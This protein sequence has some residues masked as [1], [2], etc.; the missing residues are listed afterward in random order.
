MNTAVLEL[1]P[2]LAQEA[3]G[4]WA[5]FCKAAAAAGLRVPE[6]P[7]LAAELQR[8]FAFSDFVAHSVARDPG[9]VVDLLAH[10]DLEAAYAP[11]RYRGKLAEA[12][13]AVDAEAGLA[14][15]LRKLRRREM[16]RIAWRDLAGRAD[17]NVTM[18]ELSRL[19]DACLGQTLTRLYDWQCAECGTPSAAGAAPQPLVVIGMGK[20]GARELN[21]SSDIDLVFAFPSAGETRGGPEPMD[22]HAFFVRLARR[23]VGVIGQPSADGPMYRVDLRLRPFG[24]NGPLVMSFDGMEDYY[25]Q[26][27]RE[28][29][30]YAWIKARSVAGD[31]AAGAR[32]LAAL[33][34]FVFRRYLDYGTIESIREMKQQISLEV[35]RKGLRDNI[36][37]GPGGIRE[38]EFFG[39]VFQLIRGGVLPALQAGP[40]QQTLDTL[41][42]ENLV[43]A[44][45]CRELQAAYTFLRNTEHRLQMAADR[46]THQ[47]PQEE[48][49][50]RRLAVSMGFESWTAFYARL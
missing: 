29:E 34:P 8:V 15:A 14:T 21:F 40:I 24:E 33:K 42:A 27:G 10:G 2:V 16:V 20:L 28:W 45:V 47:L 44:G 46:Q 1:P 48:P 7:G 32:L 9:L 4:K 49:A 36:K 6:R 23:L 43:P 12:L 35:G 18:A 5:A 25:Q 3:A 30:R 26:Q 38:I 37:L 13:G 50:R 22:N 11:G 31:P 39:Q 41:V 19:A 17:L